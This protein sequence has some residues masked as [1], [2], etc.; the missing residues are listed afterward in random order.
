MPEILER[1]SLRKKDVLRKILDSTRKYYGAFSDEYV[2]LYDSWLRSEGAF[3]DPEYRIG[4]NNV[5]KILAGLVEDG[6][7]IVDIGCG[8]GVW[9]ANMAKSGANV[10][11]LDHSIEALSKQREKSKDENVRSKVFVILGDGFYAP[12]R[13]DVFDGA[14]LNWVLSHIPVKENLNFLKEVERI[15]RENAW[16]MISDSYWR[17]QE[18]G[19]EQVQTRRTNNGTFEVYKYYYT[20]EE[21]R[22]LL[23]ASFCEVVNLET[24]PY[25]ILCVARK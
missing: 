9:T 25:E 14:T 23:K 4:Y 3:S 16:L 17:G 20:T 13:D 2:K 15:L 21:I 8:V 10:T 24:T 19:K 18:G 11:G 6:H 7:I 1:R 22:N 5:A 12:F